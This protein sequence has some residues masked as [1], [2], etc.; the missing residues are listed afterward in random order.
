MK[1]RTFSCVFAVIIVT[2]HANL[3]RYARI[4]RLEKK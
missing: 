1:K 3:Y 2:L 4:E